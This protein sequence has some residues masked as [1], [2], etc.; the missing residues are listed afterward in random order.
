[1]MKSPYAPCIFYLYTIPFIPGKADEA[2]ELFADEEERRQIS[3]ELA[4]L[5]GDFAAA[6][7]NYFQTTLGSR[8]RICAANV[9]LAAAA[10]MRDYE[11]VEKIL[12]EL[13]MLQKM[14][15]DNEEVYQLARLSEKIGLSSLYAD[16]TPFSNAEMSALPYE[17]R[18]YVMQFYM[19]QFHALG[20]IDKML[21]IGETALLFSQTSAGVL[22]VDIHL[23][24]M[25]ATGYVEIQQDENALFHIGKAF[26]IGLA[27]GFITPYA[28]LVPALNGRLERYLQT[29][30]PNWLQPIMKQSEV[31]YRN[32]IGAHNKFTDDHVTE[33]L[34]IREYQIAVLAERGL[35]NTQIAKVLNCSLSNVKKNLESVFHK[36]LITKRSE[37]NKFVRWQLPQ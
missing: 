9:A 35:T 27:D 37:L 30:K 32:W 12:Q 19:K 20:Q 28:E 10:S 15:Q 23:H 36:L 7:D 11:L 13:S 21:G 16:N 26:E 1:M 17:V 3:C 6:K 14:Y 24:L 25:C 8:T 34:S 22:L 31:T 4:Y 29:E 33:L 2:L 5:R 18:V